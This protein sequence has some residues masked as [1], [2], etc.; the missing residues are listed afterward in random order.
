VSGRGLTEREG[1]PR[2]EKLKREGK[3]PGQIS[4]EEERE[5]RGGGS[6]LDQASVP[7]EKGG[8]NFGKSIN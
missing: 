7:R 2:I 5:K 1:K 3:S 6:C 8:G 4:L